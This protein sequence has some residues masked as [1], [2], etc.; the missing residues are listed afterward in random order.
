MI[1][2]RIMITKGREE[3]GAEPNKDYYVLYLGD[4]VNS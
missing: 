2:K 3:W 1:L 4:V